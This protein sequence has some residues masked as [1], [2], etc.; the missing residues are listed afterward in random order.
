MIVKVNEYVYIDGYELSNLAT[1][2]NIDKILFIR[3]L[4]GEN[5]YEI[6]MFED[7]IFVDDTS[8]R[9]ILDAIQG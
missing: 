1:W 5:L 2:I 4:A 7:T 3:E 8:L 9:D 6:E